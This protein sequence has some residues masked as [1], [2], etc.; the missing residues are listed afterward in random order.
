[1]ANL[2]AH[3]SQMKQQLIDDKA[4]EALGALLGQPD[5]ELQAAVLHVRRLGL[6][7]EHPVHHCLCTCRTF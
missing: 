1:M 6:P 5:D 4:V 7:F 2:A 3:A